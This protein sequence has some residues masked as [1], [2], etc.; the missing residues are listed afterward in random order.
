MSRIKTV[1]IHVLLFISALITGLAIFMQRDLHWHYLL[2]KADLA[3]E[4]LSVEGYNFSQPGWNKVVIK[5]LRIS[6]GRQVYVLPQVQI[7][8]G[9]RPLVQA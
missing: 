7:D 1:S 2:N 8:L 4:N 5:N 3:H 9:L 6:H